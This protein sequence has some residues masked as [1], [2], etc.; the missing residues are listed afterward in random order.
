METKTIDTTISAHQASKILGV[1]PSTVSR[2]VQRGDLPGEIEGEGRART[3][4]VPLE[5]V[6][7]ARAYEDVKRSAYEA[8]V[9]DFS[10]DMNAVSEQSQRVRQLWREAF[11]HD[12]DESEDG[13]ALDRFDEISKALDELADRVQSAQ[14]SKR[15]LKEA[16]M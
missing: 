8:A 14:A 3:I 13:A 16:F 1:H 7:R 9:T 12:S 4:R 5:A 6:L 2:R 15:L 11:D 10:R